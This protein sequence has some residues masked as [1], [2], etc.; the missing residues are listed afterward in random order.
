MDTIRSL[1]CSADLDTGPYFILNQIN[2]A[3]ISLQYLIITGLKLPFHLFREFT[4][5]YFIHISRPK[6][7]PPPFVLSSIYATCL[8][9]MVTPIMM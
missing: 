9:K 2:P 5:G 4:C 6:S 3:H 1:P 8:T 7:P